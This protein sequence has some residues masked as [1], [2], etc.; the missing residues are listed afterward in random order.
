V[1]KAAVDPDGTV[2]ITSRRELTLFHFLHMLRRLAPE[3]AESLIASNDQLAGAA[4]RFPNGIESVEEEAQARR[5]AAG[6]TDAC[7]YAMAGSPKDFPMLDTLIRARQDGDFTAAM[8]R[9]LERYREDA[10]PARPN[11]AA[12]EFW[13]SASAFR[14]LIYQ[15]G[16]R[17]GRDAASLLDRI[18]DGELRLLASIEL[19]AALAGLPELPSIQREYHAAVREAEPAIGPPVAD[20]TGGGPVGPHIRCPKCRYAPRVED[21]WFCNCGHSWNTF[22]TGGICPACLNQWKITACPRCGAW[23]AHSDWYAED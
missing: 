23:S 5:R 22:D 9:A 10:D 21:R 11:L 19:A 13:P 3:L 8:E 12:H 17:I 14:S 1:E 16:Q 7:G 4:H 18:P 2:K 15:A 20:T 6:N